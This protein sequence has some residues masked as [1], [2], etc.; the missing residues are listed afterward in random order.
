MTNMSNLNKSP[1]RTPADSSTPTP[2]PS[3][4]DKPTSVKATPK[5]SGLHRTPVGLGIL[6]YF[7]AL[8]VIGPL[9]LIVINA[10]K[11]RKQIF[12]DQLGWPETWSLEYFREAMDKMDYWRA[13]WN[14]V[15]VV[16]IS[17]IIIIVVASM[18]AWVLERRRTKASNLLFVLFISTM[19]I[20]FQ[21]LMIPL[22]QYFTR[23]RFDIGDFTFRMVNSHYGLI[24][25]NVGF[26]LALSIFLFHGF[27]KSI[28]EE[29]EE[30][31]R[32]DGANPWQIFW[33]VIFP[34]LKSISVTVAIV[35]I[36]SY[37]NDYLLPS[38]VLQAPRL[39]TLPLSTFFFFGEFNIQWNLALAGLVL[40]ILPV[41]IFY[42]LAQRAILSGVM[43]GAVK[44]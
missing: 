26:G 40:T 11:G 39:R 32:I 29:M 30:S 33:R 37:W 38:L 21:A 5:N 31:A 15:K 42:L 1:V 23:W 24:F 36:I 9:Y 18:A 43:A 6:G 14:S 27:V 16:G 2:T 12:L 20:P 41:L 8:L 3:P 28:P 22:V 10:F 19:L 34:N 35:N 44:G 4:N 25:M 17:I 13:L 7:I